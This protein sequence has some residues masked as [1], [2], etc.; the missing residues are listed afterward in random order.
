MRLKLGR[1]TPK[2]V[3]LGAQTVKKIFLGRTLIYAEAE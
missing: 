3:R 1:E 2:A